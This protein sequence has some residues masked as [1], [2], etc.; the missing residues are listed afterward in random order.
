MPQDAEMTASSTAVAAA[1]TNLEELSRDLGRE[2]RW[3]ELVTA[4]V[5]R[6][7]AVSDVAERISCLKRA[8]SIYETKLQDIEKAYITLQAALAEDHR[9]QEVVREIERVA[10][11]TG[12][13]RRLIED[14]QDAVDSVADVGQRVALLLLLSGW[15]LQRHE[16]AGAEEK[17]ERALALDPTSMPAVR[18]LAD[19]LSKREDWPRL[20]EH[21]ARSGGVVLRP[22]DNAELLLGAAELYHRKLRR[23]PEATVLYGR[24]LELDPGAARALE[25]LVEITWQEENWVR[26]LPL[27]EQMAM[28]DNRSSA[29]LSHICQR[30]AMAAVRTGDFDRAR[31]HARKVLDLDAREG[32]AF[33]RDW[34][35][36]AYSRQ[37]WRD[38]RELGEWVLA[39]MGLRLTAAERAELHLRIGR[40]LVETGQDLEARDELG[41]A[42]NLDP[43]NRRSRELLVD[44]FT[45]LNQPEAALEHQRAIIEKVTNPEEK[46]QLLLEV[47]RTERDALHNSAGALSAFKKALLIKP[48]DRPVLSDMVELHSEL[49]QWRPA[50]ELLLRLAESEEAGARAPYLVA[51]ANII[52]YELHA[53]EE[54]I[55]LY[56]RALDENPGDGKT[57]ERLER[58]LSSQQ[59]WREKA[60]AY[61]RMIKRLGA[62]DSESKRVALLGVWRGLAELFRNQLQDLPSAAAA[63]EVCVKLEPSSLAEQETLAETYEA[64]GPEGLR[65]AVDQRAY[66]FERHDDPEVMIR[67]LK[68]LYR[69]YSQ[70]GLPDRAYCACAA[71]TVMQ[72]ADPQ[73]VAFYESVAAQDLP[74]P[75]AALSEEI[76]QKV[77]YHSSQERRLSLLFSCVAPVVA[78]A[79]AQDGR[80]FRL[81]DRYRL[82]A[83]TDPSGV[84]RLFELGAS[85][86]SVSRPAVYYNLEFKQDTEILNLR[87]PTGTSPTVTVGPSL[88]EGRVER[89][90]AFVVGRTLAL[91]R[92]DHLL[93]SPN[94]VETPAELAPIVHAAFKLCQPNAP[95]PNP[96]A[97]RPYLA[98][99]E[100]MLPPQALEPLSSL[101]PWLNE[102]WRTLD[103]AAWRKAAEHTANRAGLL[104][105]GDLGAAVRVLHATR[106]EA[107]GAEVLDLMR[108]S[109]SEGHLG[110]REMLGIAD[111]AGEA[112]GKEWL[113]GQG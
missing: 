57:F 82:E 23:F 80:T 97:Y 46:W 45:R 106:G 3:D 27:L 71:L 5:E 108:W 47:A 90:I 88:L 98:L 53:T 87:D 89:D 33:L 21:L 66:L 63:L 34:I 51:A 12:R 24:V 39:R 26:A 6:S 48:H 93:L 58:I 78:L 56:E 60:R 17:L 75:R 49:G 76:W 20:A 55:A 95:V 64:T 42:V 62:A 36:I 109:V 107:A 73:L 59:A 99:F 7:A 91:M 68:A 96:E 79:R 30:A 35:D 54:A 112:A 69:I 50:A 113:P 86:L 94:V 10:A 25:G 8:S 81:K 22:S 40:S 38:V 28:A 43:G 19:L 11:L 41:R 32:E 2:G 61:R 84:A 13:P 103:L 52:H 85:V 4:L 65:S 44:I 70:A 29:D 111:S 14:H 37:W 31:A 74:V 1:D 15:H 105:C 72:A 101:A 16:L 110:L 67:Q 83:K 100:R 92:P 104:F 77:L 102:S 18:R 9:N